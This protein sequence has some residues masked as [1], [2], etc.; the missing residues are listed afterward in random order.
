MSEVLHLQPENT[1]RRGESVSVN[2]VKIRNKKKTDKAL[3]YVRER[4]KFNS[5]FRCFTPQHGS[6]P[7]EPT[8]ILTDTN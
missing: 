3:N 6:P 8:L 4:Q 2:T 7:P 5:I 1:Q